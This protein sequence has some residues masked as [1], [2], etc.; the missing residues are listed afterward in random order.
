[1]IANCGV[2]PYQTCLGPSAFSRNPH[3]LPLSWLIIRHVAHF[4]LFTF[5]Q[6]HRHPLPYL[7]TSRQQLFHSYPICTPSPPSR[8]RHEQPATWSEAVRPPPNTL[9]NVQARF[10]PKLLLHCNTGFFSNQY[11]KLQYSAPGTGQPTARFFRVRN[12]TV[13]LFI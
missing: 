3:L 13:S 1:M 11:A 6:F 4:R 8:L 9:N 10:M 5:G 2:L 7:V 12:N